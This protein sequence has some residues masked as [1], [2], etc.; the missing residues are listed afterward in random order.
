MHEVYEFTNKT[1][2]MCRIDRLLFHVREQLK[3]LQHQGGHQL[4]V[5]HREKLKYLSWIGALCEEDS[6]WNLNAFGLQE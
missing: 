6:I 5:E 4:S 1:T 3:P 2:I